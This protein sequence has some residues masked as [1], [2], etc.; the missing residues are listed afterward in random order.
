ME[1]YHDEDY[2]FF[3][4]SISDLKSELGLTP[5]TRK[6]LLEKLLPILEEERK[7]TI[8]DWRIRDRYGEFKWLRMLTPSDMFILIVEYY[9]RLPEKKQTKIKDKAESLLYDI[10]LFEDWFED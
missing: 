3:V 7:I 8:L 5:H 4:Y 10:A 2:E 1:R 6:G 9:K